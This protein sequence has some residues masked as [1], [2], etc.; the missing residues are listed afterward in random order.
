MYI[1]MHIHFLQQNFNFGTSRFAELK[2]TCTPTVLCSHTKTAIYTNTITAAIEFT[3]Y[4]HCNALT[5]RAPSSLACAST[6]SCETNASEWRT[7]H[8]SHIHQPSPC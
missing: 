1:H 6:S 7:K 8:H 5:E 3:K 4:N 2:E